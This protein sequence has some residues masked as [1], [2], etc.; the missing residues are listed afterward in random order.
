[1]FGRHPNL[2]IDVALGINRS[3][4]RP[5][6]HHYVVEFRSGLQKAYES[7]CKA[8]DTFK[9]RHKQ[10]RDPRCRAAVLQKGDRVLVKI[11][12]FTGKHKLFFTLGA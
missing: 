5:S 12:A 3:S 1:M 6:S 7:A 10:L 2:S 8:S 4:D 9:D 11:L